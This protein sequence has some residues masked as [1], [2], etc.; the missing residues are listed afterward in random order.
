MG[1][2]I[3]AVQALRAWRDVA[4]VKAGGDRAGA[5]RAQRV[6]RRRQSTWR[7]SAGVAFTADGG[8][9]GG[10][11]CRSRAARSRSCPQT[12][13]T[14]GPHS[15]AWPRSGRSS[16]PR[17]SAPS[18]SSPIR[19]SWPR[20]PPDVVQAERDK[21][22]TLKDEARRRCERPRRPSATSCSRELFGMRFGLD[23]MRRLMTAL[24][25]PQLRFR[26][27][28]R[29]RHQREVLDSPHDRGDPAPA[30]AADRRLPVAASGLVRRADP[31]STTQDLEPA[32]FAGAIE[33]AA[34][35][36]ELVDR[37]L[38][39]DDRVTQ[40]EL[41]TAAAYS[42]LARRGSRSR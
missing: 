39:P 40:F 18:A 24:G 9:P 27:D 2:V 31:R 14:S 23:R 36:A 5:A 28:P 17:S 33:R 26:F 37:S 21:L 35:A 16:R 12:T 42:E 19:V 25:H 29:R 41:L 32:E 3:E 13:S 38:G 7:G 15:G 1:R 30:W 20:R 6:T 8:E 4:G 10:D 22:R 34:H 11:A